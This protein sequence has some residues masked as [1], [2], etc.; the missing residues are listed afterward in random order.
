MESH[1]SFFFDKLE[2]KF[3]FK[4]SRTFFWIITTLT[5]LTIVT[6]LMLLTYSFIPPVKEEVEEQLSPPKPFISYDEIMNELIPQLPTNDLTEQKQ[7][8]I[9]KQQS[10]TT[11][12]DIPIKNKKSDL[13]ILLDSLGT[14]FPSSWEASYRNYPTSLDFSGRVTD[15]RKELVSYGLKNKVEFFLKILDDDANKIY[16]LKNMLSVITKIEVTERTRAIES[17]VNL[18][19]SKWNKYQNDLEK[20]RIE[21]NERTLQAEERYVSAKIYKQELENNALKGLIGGTVLI[22][23]L[24]MFLGLLAIER[25]TRALRELIEEK[26]HNEE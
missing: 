4:V 10:N 23:F 17:Y 16:V 18:L 13:D 6:S 1:N 12:L 5:V 2:K 19:E 15:Y 8:K 7:I 14:Y 11:P 3:V 9:K 26:V 21:N 20:I 24:G 25:N 22:A